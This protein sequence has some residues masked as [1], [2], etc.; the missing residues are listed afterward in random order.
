MKNSVRG[1]PD[2]KVR[3][4]KITLWVYWISHFAHFQTIYSQ[5]SNNSQVNKMT[6]ANLATVF[7]PNVLWVRTSWHRADSVK[8]ILILYVLIG[9]DMNLSRLHPATKHARHD[10]H[11]RNACTHRG[12]LFQGTFAAI[13]HVWSASRN[14]HSRNA[15]T[16]SKKAWSSCCGTKRRANSCC[17]SWFKNQTWLSLP[18]SWACVHRSRKRNP[19]KKA[20]KRRESLLVEATA[21]QRRRG[22]STLN[23]SLMQ[24]DDGDD[25]WCSGSMGTRNIRGTSARVRAIVVFTESDLPVYGGIWPN[26][27]TV[28]TLYGAKHGV[29]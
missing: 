4:H 11:S 19:H 18:M 12:I 29:L 6:S 5:V 25:T 26:N 23:F 17:A 28:I 10:A 8:D 13:M 15:G 2:D 3:T 20:G 21:H 7:A 22:D 9:P 14:A 27:G 16:R 24:R 1:E